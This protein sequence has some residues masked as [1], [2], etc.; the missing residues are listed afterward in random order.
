M[1]PN[2]MS[3]T[4]SVKGFLTVPW[5]GLRADVV[6]YPGP[7]DPDGQR[8]WVLEDPARGNNFR[9]G[10]VEGEVLFRLLTE[11]DPDAALANLYETSPLRPSME[12]VAG[13][14]SMLQREHLAIL[15]PKE[16]IRRES[17]SDH[18]GDPT[19]FSQLLESYVFFRIPLIRPDAFLT[20]TISY[21]SILWSPVFR[22]IYLICGVLGVFFRGSGNR[23]V[24][25]DH[26]LSAHAPGKC[27]IFLMSCTAQN[28]T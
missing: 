8:S 25:R 2:S 9:L 19:I 3:N 22:Y 1:N 21:V 27:C 24:L 7:V 18:T 15:P 16:A 17:L 14:I 26:Q 20:R 13:F 5:L 4:P 23:V 12:E 28:R 11:R 6:L 10:Y